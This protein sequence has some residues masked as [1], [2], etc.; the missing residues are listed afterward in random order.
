MA[1]RETDVAVP[2][3]PPASSQSVRLVMQANAT[4]ATRPELALRSALHRAGLRFRKNYR[5]RTVGGSVRP[6]IVFPGKRV[7][8]FVDGCFWH[9]CPTHGNQPVT[10][11][12]YWAA[13]LERN[14]RRDIYVNTALRADGWQVVRLWEH[15]PLDHAVDGVLTALRSV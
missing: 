5:I 6:D 7:A 8:V 3:A 10:N 1:P 2:S 9:G 15:T 13:K 12:F 14:R 11:A 4:L